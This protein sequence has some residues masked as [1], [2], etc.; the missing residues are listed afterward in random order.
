MILSLGRDAA[1]FHLA[2]CPILPPDHYLSFLFFYLYF[3]LSR[4][5][6]GLTA[7]GLFLLHFQQSLLVSHSITI[8]IQPNIVHNSSQR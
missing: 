3:F 8:N 1:C 2:P 6:L 4:A 7:C 5:V